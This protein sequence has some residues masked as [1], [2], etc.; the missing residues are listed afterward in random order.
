MVT[1]TRYFAFDGKEFENATNCHN[2]E[3]EK[4]N[5]LIVLYEQLNKINSNEFA[6]FNFGCDDTKIDIIKINNIYEKIIVHNLIISYN[7]YNEEEE[8]ELNETLSKVLADKD[9][10]LLVFRGIDDTDYVYNCKSL[11]T[12]INDLQ[13]LKSTLNFK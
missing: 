13:T 7:F 5:K 12:L 6:I 11:K 2:Y 10:L 9:D 8:K 1:L 4:R 3:K